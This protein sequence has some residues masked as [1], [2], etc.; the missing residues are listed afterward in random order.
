LSVLQTD[1][2]PRVRDGYINSGTRELCGGPSRG[3]GPFKIFFEVTGIYE[4]NYTPP[5]TESGRRLARR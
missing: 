2:E 1:N 3:T 4:L 5:E